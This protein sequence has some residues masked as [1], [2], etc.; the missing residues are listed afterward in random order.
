MGVKLAGKKANRMLATQ[1]GPRVTPSGKKI[2][3]INE[4]PD[5]SIY[6][7]GL[8][9]DM[10]HKVVV[11]RD[12]RDGIALADR[13]EP[14]LI[15]L[16]NDMP[17]M[18]GYEISAALSERGHTSFIPVLMFSDS[19]DPELVSRILNGFAED[20]VKKPIIESEF[21]ARVGALIRCTHRATH[22]KRVHHWIIRRLASHAQRRGYQVYSRYI[23]HS[24]NAP[25]G[26]RGPLPDLLVMR[27][28]AVTAYL[29]ESVESLQDGRA[30]SRWESLEKMENMRLHIVAQSREAA[31]LAKKIK[32]EE[33]FGAHIQ[34]S[35]TR[36]SRRRRLGRILLPSRM[37]CAIAT[38]LAIVVS[39]FASGVVPNF[40]FTS[41][42]VDNSLKVQMDIYQPKDI[43]RHLYRIDRIMENLNK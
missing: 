2:L 18:N 10:G 34:W 30:V 42:E 12:A 24:P 40:L 43:E 20:V 16:D 33:G 36:T 35:R 19:R 26:W 22:E 37:Q 38:L 4:D 23:E 14:D 6:V 9:K 21:L 41:K 13:E 25:M 11:A 27:R 8:L 3:I 15:I 1:S 29:V 32:R 39:L 5:T 17:E 31:Q 28:G 7:K